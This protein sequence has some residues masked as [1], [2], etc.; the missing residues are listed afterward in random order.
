[1]KSVSSMSPRLSPQQLLQ[2]FLDNIPDLVYFKDLE[3]RF[4][5]VSARGLLR[6]NPATPES[7]IGKT[8]F[9]VFDEAHA[10]PAFEDEQ[11]IIATGVP[12]L[13][14]L[15]KEVWPD[16]SVT[17]C[18]TT[19]MPLR[20]EEGKIVGTFGISR[21]VTASKRLQEQLE[22]AHKDLVDASRKAGMAD[23]AT[24][25]LHNVGNV[26]NSV[27][28]AA[29]QLGEGL[30][31][32][33]VDGVAKLSALLAEQTQDLPAFFASARGR[34]VPSYVAQLAEHL[35][36]ER[37]RLL[38]ELVELRRA[39]D[40]IKDIVAMQQ[41]FAGSPGMVEA[42]DPVVLV[43]DS[44][45]LNVAAL[46]RH[47]VRVVRDF[48][49]SPKVLA[50]RTRVLQILV[51]LVGNAKHALDDGAPPEKRLTLRV[52]PAGAERVRLVVADN[53]VGIASENL[54]RIFAHGFT[55]KKTGHGFG[56]HSAANAAS[57]LGGSLSVHSDGPGKGA[58]FI[59][60]LPIA[61]PEAEGEVKT[62]GAD[63]A[64]TLLVRKAGI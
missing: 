17:W 63:D 61:P 38:G 37:D 33:R 1:M 32:S 49:P 26:L 58:E 25:V 9:D 35:K 64:A 41:S 28:V 3:S 12:I 34:Q 24:G 4:L 20:D 5:L 27:N 30:R 43:E 18:V 39:I 16:G 54:A 19:K 50:D 11:Q 31:K 45:R 2:A 13:D 59:L 29:D 10:R 40:H 8:D 15:E 36:A 23:V 51:N 62:A 42:L 22:T 6:H 21:D 56:L 48:S 57:E 60:E 47:D 52:E 7:V 53:G 44:L 14:K 46:M 55:T